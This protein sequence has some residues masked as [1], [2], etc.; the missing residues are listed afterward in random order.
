MPILEVLADKTIEQ[1]VLELEE[2]H[3]INSI[4]HYKREI[5]ELRRK[6][7]EEVTDLERNEMYQYSQIKEKV[8]KK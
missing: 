1:S 7:N 2:T 8:D 5:R 4:D 6:R 3:E